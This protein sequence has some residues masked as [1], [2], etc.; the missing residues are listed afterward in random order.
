V[1]KRWQILLGEALGGI[2]PT[3]NAMTDAE[4]K[5]VRSAPK[6]MTASNCWW[7]IYRLAPNVADIADGILKDR[8]AAR[9]KAKRAQEGPKP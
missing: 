3:L 1:S 2:I 9:R 4:L 6:K 5:L 8:S 7:L